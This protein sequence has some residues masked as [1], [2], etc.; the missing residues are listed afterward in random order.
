MENIHWQAEPGKEDEFGFTLADY[1]LVGERMND[2]FNEAIAKRAD[3]S[4]WNFLKAFGLPAQPN[5]VATMVWMY[6]RAGVVF[7]IANGFV[8]LTEQGEVSAAGEPATP[9][10]NVVPFRSPNP[11]MN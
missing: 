4:A 7:A 3:R 11:E 6:M 5:D 1:N 10:G 2:A 8:S 9:E